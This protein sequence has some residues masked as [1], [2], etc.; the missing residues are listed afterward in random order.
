MP[1]AMTLKAEGRLGRMSGNFLSLRPLNLTEA[2]RGDKA[3]ISPAPSCSLS[4][5]PKAS[6]AANGSRSSAG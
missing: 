5:T 2:Q 3:N 1:S 6:S 4:R